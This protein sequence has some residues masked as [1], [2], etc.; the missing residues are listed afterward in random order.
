MKTDSIA[1]LDCGAQ[2][3][4]VIDRRVREL[5]VRSE[6]F[7]L[8][9]TAD[10]LKEYDGII[11]SGGPNSVWDG[12]G[13]EYDPKIF[14]LGVPVLGICYGMHLI[15][16]HFDGI[17]SPGVKKEYGETDIEIDPTCPLFTDLD[18]TQRVLMSHGD[19]VEKLAEGFVESAH[20]EDVCASMYDRD[21]KIYA[22]QFHPEVD[23]TVNGVRMLDSFLKKVCELEGNYILEDR[24]ETALAKI[25]SQVGNENVL[26]LVSGGV[27]S[28]VS[29]ALLLKALGPERV[30]AIH[31]DHGLMR[32]DESDIICRQLEQFGLKHLRRENAEDR[33]L[34]SIVDM[35]GEK[36]GPLVRLIDPEKKRNLI[37]HV[38]VELVNDVCAELGLDP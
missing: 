1:I 27:D 5:A 21:R 24:I 31:V 16:K 35:N 23:L 18:K 12:S 14:D 4:K 2:Y 10:K 32:K 7:P 15:N 37:G 34:N 22:V 38:F 8:N 20:S 29:T 11:L 3:T 19:S 17:I 13:L 26:V 25:K 9:I 28:A 30:F 33:F 6:V 36:V